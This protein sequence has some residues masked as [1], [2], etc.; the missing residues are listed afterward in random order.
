MDGTSNSANRATVPSTGNGVSPGGERLP[1]THPLPANPRATSSTRQ[2]VVAGPSSLAPNRPGTLATQSG[3]GRL[4]PGT[5]RAGARALDEETELGDQQRGRA[6]DR[7]GVFLAGPLA[8]P[9]LSSA[10]SLP[11]FASANG[12]DPS[13]GTA[14][15][16][17]RVVP[18]R[19]EGPDAPFRGVTSLSVPRLPPPTLGGDF[20]VS[21]PAASPPRPRAP[22]AAPS[23]PALEA[24]ASTNSLLSGRLSEFGQALRAASELVSRPSRVFRR[25]SRSESPPF[26]WDSAPPFTSTGEPFAGDRLPLL[27]AS[28][29]GNL[30]SPSHVAGL[31]CGGGGMEDIE[32]GELNAVRERAARRLGPA[33]RRGALGGEA[34]VV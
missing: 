8:R 21:F 31:G 18:P 15:N 30:F 14:N 6:T 25:R 24:S 10:A 9:N 33:G 3:Y 16:Q 22:V 4:G 5:A 28:S 19:P 32:L 17:R 26:F 11:A 12:T 23:R 20:G 13:V 7:R 34:G 29:T 27:P 2:G 1:F